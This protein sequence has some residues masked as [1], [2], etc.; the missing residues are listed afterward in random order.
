MILNQALLERSTTFLAERQYA[1]LTAWQR[2]KKRA[3]D[4]ILGVLAT[5]IDVPPILAS[6]DA[7]VVAPHCDLAL[8]VVQQERAPARMVVRLVVGHGK[9][10]IGF[11]LAR[12]KPASFHDA[13]IE[14]H[15]VNYLERSHVARRSLVARKKEH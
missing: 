1:S 10:V 14:N 15:R 13:Y 9:S 6:P 2:A 7:L 5:V 4:L 12:A 11:M 8:M 3:S